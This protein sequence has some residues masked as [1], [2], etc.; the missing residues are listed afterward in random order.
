M[1]MTRL[2]NLLLVSLSLCLTVSS[3]NM[4]LTETVNFGVYYNNC[5]YPYAKLVAQSP[6][7]DYVIATSCSSSSPKQNF[8]IAMKPDGSAWFNE[9]FPVISSDLDPFWGSIWATN[10]NIYTCGIGSNVNE[11]KLRVDKLSWTGSTVWQTIPHNSMTVSDTEVGACSLLDTSILYTADYYF[12]ASIGLI[13]TSDGTLTKDVNVTRPTGS[14]FGANTRRPDGKYIIAGI[15]EV[16]NATEGKQ[17]HNIYIN[18]F[19]IDTGK[20]VSTTIYDASPMLTLSQFS[21]KYKL[22]LIPI[23]TSYVL[24]YSVYVSNV[25]YNFLIKFSADGTLGAVRSLPTGSHYYFSVAALGNNTAMVY[26][27]SEA[28][29][30]AIFDENL[31]PIQEFGFPLASSLGYYYPLPLYKHPTKDAL[32]FP[33]GLNGKVN[34]YIVDNLPACS[35]GK[36]YDDSVQCH[37]CDITCKTCSIPG[38]SQACTSCLDGLVA[39]DITAVTFNCTLSGK[40]VTMLS[41]IKDYA[42]HINS[43]VSVSGWF[44]TS[45]VGF[46][47]NFNSNIH[48]CPAIDF[49]G[50]LVKTHGSIALDISERVWQT[51]S[52]TLSASLSSDEIEQY[53]TSSS[54]STASFYDCIVTV[55]L[56]DATTT[57][58]GAA[59]EVNFKVVSTF[60]NG[61]VASKVALG[62]YDVFDHGSSSQGE[63][64]IPVTPKVCLD[65]NCSTYGF[66]TSYAKD[67]EV[68]ILHVPDM[69]NAKIV[70][71]TG[72]DVNFTE[73]GTVKNGIDYLVSQQNRTDGNLLTKIKLLDSSASPITIT[74]YLWTEFSSS[75]RLLKTDNNIV[76]STFSF[77][78]IESHE[79]SENCEDQ[80]LGC[81]QAAW[82]AGIA[83]GCAA[84][85][86]AVGITIYC[87]RRKS[88]QPAHPRPEP[89]AESSKELTRS[90][91]PAIGIVTEKGVIVEMV[92]A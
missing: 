68:S 62:S 79:R 7:G 44:K 61:I 80:P 16:Y 31:K 60:E 18:V 88:K 59:F 83:C 67:E 6:R 13:S 72:I 53:C 30:V 11:L 37:D 4:N 27:K 48:S 8:L 15:Y 1:K 20:S 33:M 54:N 90:P 26:Y 76:K 52:T 57:I 41:C 19:D 87:I 14:F 47:L 56:V 34:I 86:L 66:K 70:N 69:K 64:A 21:M 23:G 2:S 58:K 43:G 49:T 71:L 5:T 35:E 45:E 3:F 46:S 38:N 65:V 25:Y 42:A 73:N 92:K 55:F 75:R 40:V 91:E 50:E 84:I 9:T 17:H 10:D 82:I 28:L 36:A 51:N 89:K 12:N 74:F 22:Q 39:Y 78:V 24:A 32:V 81:H 85:L 77:L 29:T 63:V